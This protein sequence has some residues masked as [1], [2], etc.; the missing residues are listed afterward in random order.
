MS[1]TSTAS[2]AV[3]DP[4]KKSFFDV[5]LANDNYLLTLV[6]TGAPL[7]WLTETPPTGFLERNGAS[8]DRTTY[9]ALFAIIGTI[10]GAVDASHFNLPDHRG[11]FPRYWDHAKAKDPDSATRT[12][13]TAAGATM[14]AGDHV[15][16]EQADGFKAHTHN[17]PTA[18]GGAAY[19]G[20]TYYTNNDTN[21]TATSS[22]GG[23]ETRPVNH[24]E[25]PIIKY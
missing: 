22:T 5:L 17:R 16:T 3:G 25:M 15:G 11:S 14:T 6:P 20:G 8:L 19:V 1:F 10:Y 18:T 13:V 23:N 21:A 9:A 12:A 2:W 4:S 24:Y 7:T